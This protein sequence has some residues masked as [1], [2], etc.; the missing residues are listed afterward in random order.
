MACLQLEILIRSLV[1]RMF[2][3]FGRLFEAVRADYRVSRRDEC[4]STGRVRPRSAPRG[5]G[6]IW[7][8]FSEVDYIFLLHLPIT[9]SKSTRHVTIL[10]DVLRFA[11][12]PGKRIG[13]PINPAS[14]PEI[15]FHF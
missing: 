12:V 2:R 1:G 14:D 8:P 13:F 7:E 9:P 15:Q 11:V 4:I 5:P 3:I 10:Q 6:D